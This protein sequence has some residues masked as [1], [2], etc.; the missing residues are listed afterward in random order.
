[1]KMYGITLTALTTDEKEALLN[2]LDKVSFMSP[3]VIKGSKSGAAEAVIVFWDSNASFP[4]G[5]HIPSICPRQEIPA[6][7][8]DAFRANF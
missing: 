6:G 1:M 8:Q 7:Y 3:E 2:E 4:G 5:V